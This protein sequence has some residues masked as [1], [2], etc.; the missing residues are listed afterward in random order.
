MGFHIKQRNSAVNKRRGFTPLEMNISNRARKRFLTGFTLIELLVVIASISI[1]MAIL[2]PAL[3]RAREQGRTVRCLANLKQWNL[4]FA[5]YTEN[6]NGKFWPGLVWNGNAGFWWPW[7]LEDRLKDWKK[8][9]IWLCPTAQKPQSEAGANLNI[10][11]A[12]GVYHDKY[13]DD[14]T[15]VKY[16]AGSSGISGSYGLNGYVLSIPMGHNF[17]GGVPAEDGWRTAYVR[18]ASYVP[19]FMDAL[20]FDLWPLE[21]EAPADEEFE[22]WSGNSMA[23]CCINRHAGFVCSSFLDFSARKVGLKELWK[24]KWHRSF[25]T[26]GPWTVAGND[27]APPDWPDWLK[28]FKEY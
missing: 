6:N 12:W 11:N 1:L 28:N 14:T 10:F 24:L 18:G 17:S 16:S 5:M 27:G 2:V 13:E 8:N 26:A 19:L 3:H 4:I 23:R 20:R 25:D 21:T 9:G 15:R 7:Q 22:A